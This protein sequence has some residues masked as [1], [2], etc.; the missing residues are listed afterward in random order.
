MVQV[1]EQTK[2]A[3]R[4]SLTKPWALRSGISRTLPD[5][6]EWPEDMSA[7]RQFK[8]DVICIAVIIAL[9]WATIIAEVVYGF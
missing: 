4:R 6:G 7:Y 8:H 3:S 9:F 2:M 5:F 1:R